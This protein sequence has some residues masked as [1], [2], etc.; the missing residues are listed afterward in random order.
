MLVKGMLL[1]QKRTKK[2]K[3]TLKFAM[4]ILMGGTMQGSLSFREQQH[5]VLLELQSKN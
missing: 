5:I 2:H 3:S 1:E 4:P